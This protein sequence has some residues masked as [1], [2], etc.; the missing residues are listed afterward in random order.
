[1]QR[2]RGR[3]TQ[4]CSQNR[5]RP[6]WPECNGQRRKLERGWNTKQGLI[7]HGVDLG[8][9]LKAGKPKKVSRGVM[10]LN[11]AEHAFSKY[12]LELLEY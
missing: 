11:G 2:P 8:F 7:S 1:M 3:K 4:V 12:G 9:Y 10:W 5:E 6:S